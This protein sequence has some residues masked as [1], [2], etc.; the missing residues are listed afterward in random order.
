MLNVIERVEIVSHSVGGGLAE[1]IEIENGFRQLVQG[2]DA[3]NGEN[4]VEI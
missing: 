1:L 4:V 3:V 2:A